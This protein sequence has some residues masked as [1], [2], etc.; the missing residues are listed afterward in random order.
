M[1]IN[2]DKR[3]GR[4]RKKMLVN[5]FIYA[6]IAIVAL[7]IAIAIPNTLTLQGKLTNAAGGVLSGSYTMVF[8]IYDIP[9]FSY[10]NV[11]NQTGGDNTAISNTTYINYTNILWEDNRTVTTDAN[12]IYDVILSN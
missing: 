2:D 8:R 1:T 6:V 7:R 4:G 3:D 11:S 9:G 12:G 5:I 10:F